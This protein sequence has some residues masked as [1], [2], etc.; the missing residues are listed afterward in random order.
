MHTRGLIGAFAGFALICAL[1]SWTRSAAFQNRSRRRY[2]RKDGVAVAAIST[3]PDRFRP[4]SALHRLRF[5]TR[6]FGIVAI[7]LTPMPLAVRAALAAAGLGLINLSFNG[8]G[9]KAV[10]VP[11]LARTGR[12]TRPRM[13]TS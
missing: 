9:F 11:L 13:A 3:G 7:V 1:W 2:P 5:V 4:A 12:K 10:E 8:S 6:S